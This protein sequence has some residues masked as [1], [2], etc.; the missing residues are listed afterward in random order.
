MNLYNI[1]MNVDF[2]RG[3]LCSI[4]GSYKVA[5]KD[6]ANA[7]CNLINEI[8]EKN[9]INE[10]IRKFSVYKVETIDTNIVG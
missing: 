1:T 9:N 7:T 2:Y 5:A 10:R 4:Q 8:I 6:L 3:G